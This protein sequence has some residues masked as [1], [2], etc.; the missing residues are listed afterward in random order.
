MQYT[1][2]G[3]DLQLQGNSLMGMDDNRMLISVAPEN[4]KN[5]NALNRKAFLFVNISKT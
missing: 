5:N 4:R 1:W 2:R 3:D